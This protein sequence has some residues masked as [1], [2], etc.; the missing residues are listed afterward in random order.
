[1]RSCKRP[2]PRNLCP[3]TYFKRVPTI[4]R[5]IFSH[6]ED[7]SLKV[8][9]DVTRDNADCTEAIDRRERRLF[10][11]YS[12]C[13]AKPKLIDSI[14]MQNAFVGQLFVV[15]G[16]IIVH[17]KQ[18]IKT[19]VR[20]W[21]CLYPFKQLE[22]VATFNLKRADG[23]GYINFLPP[24]DKITAVL[25]ADYVWTVLDNTNRFAVLAEVHIG[26][27]WHGQL[28]PGF[29]CDLLNMD[30]HNK[31][32]SWITVEPNS[33]NQR[34]EKYRRSTL[35]LSQDVTYPVL[36][37][38]GYAR[39]GNFD[40][41]RSHGMFSLFCNLYEY[42]PATIEVWH[43]DTKRLLRRVTL[44]TDMPFYR[45][46]S[47]FSSNAKMVRILATGESAKDIE[48]LTLDLED[49]SSIPVKL[50]GDDKWVAKQRFGSSC[51]LNP[52]CPGIRGDIIKFNRYERRLKFKYLGLKTNK[53]RIH[54]EKM[55][56]DFPI[57]SKRN[58]EYNKGDTSFNWRAV[59]NGQ[60]IVVATCN[61]MDFSRK[62]HLGSID[63]YKMQ[64]CN[65]KIK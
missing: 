2:P 45:I 51:V 18:Q 21:L 10:H 48:A 23:I 41:I 9:Q 37:H 60:F 38:F 47:S 14:P 16:G 59:M 33:T 19:P 1:M 17:Y 12:S 35:N 53:G 24:N 55:V 54:K 8:L 46:E 13:Q 36:T 22:T 42:Q 26:Y 44:Y 20:Y 61:F 6:L 57:L 49:D 25:W 4:T 63:V 11:S 30:S 27:C 56:I 7:S 62:P 43:W 39:E 34:G 50:T 65:C 32:L 15:S 31:V 52:S 40:H 28:L 3:I 5:I 58:N 29:S 64:K